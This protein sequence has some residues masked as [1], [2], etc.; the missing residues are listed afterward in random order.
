IRPADE[1]AVGLITF[2]TIGIAG[3]LGCLLGGWASNG[4]G[5]G[6]AAGY[7]MIL[8]G[9]CCLLS[10]M[11]VDSHW[12]VVIVLLVVWGAAFIADSPAFSTALSE[13]AD[14]RYTVTA[15]TTQTA[16]GFLLTLVTINIVPVTAEL[17]GWQYAYVVLA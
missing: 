1:A 3:G 16:I 7:A 4:L 13:V 17:I 9:L 8:S 2:V 5:R 6:R 11:L 15:L 14:R 12:P 10:A